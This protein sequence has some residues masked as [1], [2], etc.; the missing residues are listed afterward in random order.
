MPARKN[1]LQPHLHFD[2]LKIL[3]IFKPSPHLHLSPQEQ[4]QSHFEQSHFLQSQPHVQASLQEQSLFSWQPQVHSFAQLHL[5]SSGQA[6]A[7]A[8]PLS[9]INVPN[10]INVVNSFFIIFPFYY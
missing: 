7:N 1:Y 9:P 8:T 10:N 5:Q 3:K 2:F 6:A 4:P